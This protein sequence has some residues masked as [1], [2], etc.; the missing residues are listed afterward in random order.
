MTRA[1]LIRLS[2]EVLLTSAAILGALCLVMVVAGIAFG[3]R[4]LMFRSGSMSPTIDTG[5]LS[6]SR[7]VGAAGLHHGDIVSVLAADG[8]RVTHRVVSNTAADGH[9]QL[10]LKGDANDVVDQQVYNVTSAQKVIFTI[11]KMGYVVDWLSRAPG[12]YLVA[13]YVGLLLML[14]GRRSAGAGPG[15]GKEDAVDV[16]ESRP[17]TSDDTDPTRRRHTKSGVVAAAVLGLVLVA[18]AGWTLPTWATWND[19]V[20]VNGTTFSSGT[21]GAPAAPTGVTC[22]PGVLGGPNKITISWD[23]VPTATNY[24]VTPT[25][26][27]ASD[28]A[29][30]SLVLTGSNN[31]SGTAVVQAQIGSGPFSANSATIHYTFGNANNKANTC[32]GVTP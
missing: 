17:A 22:T 31:A 10:T 14:I 26:G 1:R 32:D 24:R 11:P 19:N 15:D 30:T 16:Q 29:G 5:D 18:V 28:T 27:T 13:L 21:W 12:V 25:P 4:P 6:I 20:S 3:V 7:T 2:R 8:Q 9:R 23:A